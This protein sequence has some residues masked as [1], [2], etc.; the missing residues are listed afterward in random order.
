[1][2]TYR[3]GDLVLIAFPYSSG[4]QTKNRPAMVVM[5]TGDTDVLVARVTTQ[6]VQCNHDIPIEEWRD[7]GLLAPS[8][9]RLHRL[10]TLE[11]SLVQR[12]LGCVQD[13]DRFTISAALRR[14]Y[15]S[16]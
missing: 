13:A 8:A 16:W 4:A 11:K 15:E 5:D 2:T 12:H 6:R 7:A 10:A 9:V 1:M 3:S 14:I